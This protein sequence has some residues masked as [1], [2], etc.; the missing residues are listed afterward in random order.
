[1][2]ILD[3]E[4]VAETLS[5]DLVQRVADAAADVFETGPGRTWT[6]MRLLPP[7]HYAENH[8]EAAA[9]VFVSVLKADVGTEED[10]ARWAETLAR[11]LAG[12]CSTSVE[13]VHVLFLPGPV[14][15]TSAAASATRCTRSDDRVSA[16][17]ST[18][19]M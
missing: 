15:N 4:L 5:S 18:S 3:V 1:M 10:R 7:A 11:A 6:R 16:T 19:R 8:C 9:P 14:S 17:S 2:P 12:V 13:H